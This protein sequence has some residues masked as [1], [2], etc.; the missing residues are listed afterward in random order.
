[1]ICHLDSNIQESSNPVGTLK[2]SKILKT[3]EYSEILLRF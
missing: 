1:M 2:I 3:C